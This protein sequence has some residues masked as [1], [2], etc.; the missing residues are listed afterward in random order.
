MRQS[1]LQHTRIAVPESR[2]LDLFT[3]MLEKFGARVMRCPLVAVVDIDDTTELHAWIGR[4]C[5]GQHDSIVFYTGEGVSRIWAAADKFGMKAPTFEALET[6][7]KISRGPKPVAALRKLGL[8]ADLVAENPT[9][10][11]VLALLSTLPLQGMRI[12]VQLYPQADEAAL[13]TTLE[14]A[15]ATFD[16][17]LPYRYVSDEADERVALLIEEMAAGRVDLIAFTS[18]PQVRRLTDVAQRL[19]LTTEL[20]RAFDKTKV[21]AIGPLAA[22]AVTEAGGRTAIQPLRNFHL[23]PLVAEIVRAL[24]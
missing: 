4:L 17:V 16:P 12:G 21:A 8:D 1:P 20:A 6:V 2:E 19:G 5:Q 18:S 22:R 13:R 9:S 3:S 7:R 11:G 10:E 24:S 23:K 14:R 15:G